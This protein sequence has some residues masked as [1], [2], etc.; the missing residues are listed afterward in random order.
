VERGRPVIRVYH[1]PQLVLPPAQRAQGIELMLLQNMGRV[2]V[3]VGTR[4]AFGVRKE[5]D[6]TMGL[7]ERLLHLLFIEPASPR[8]NFDGSFA[9]RMPQL[10]SRRGVGWDRFQV[11]V[12]QLVV[13]PDSSG[14]LFLSREFPKNSAGERADEGMVQIP[15]APNRKRPR[16][17]LQEEAVD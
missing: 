3:R 5:V 2:S 4:S 9:D 13:E 14:R 8:G 16:P 12:H 15:F 6:F 11:Q 17:L 10:N 7:L 1:Q